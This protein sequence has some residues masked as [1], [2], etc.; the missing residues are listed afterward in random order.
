MRSSAFFPGLRRGLTPALGLRVRDRSLRQT[1][2][3][4]GTARHRRPAAKGDSS[5]T[6]APHRQISAARVTH[7]PRAVRPKT[8]GGRSAGGLFAQLGCQRNA[9]DCQKPLAEVS[10]LLAGVGDLQG[11]ARLRKVQVL[12]GAGLKDGR[13][14]SAHTRDWKRLPKSNE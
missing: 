6:S 10:S 12:H 3:H 7:D 4:G 1:S 13:P 8:G 9:D 5:A 14:Q 11:M 2:R